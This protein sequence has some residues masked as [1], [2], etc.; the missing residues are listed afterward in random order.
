MTQKHA[1]GDVYRGN[2]NPHLQFHFTVESPF[3][4]LNNKTSLNKHEQTL[5]YLQMNYMET[6]SEIDQCAPL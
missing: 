6:A 5:Y 3:S 2:E 1:E 4:R